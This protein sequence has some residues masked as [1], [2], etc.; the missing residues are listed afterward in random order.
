MLSFYI[1]SIP[2]YDS[3]DG[4]REYMTGLQLKTGAERPVFGSTI[5]MVR[6]DNAFDGT[7]VVPREQIDA[8]ILRILDSGQWLPKS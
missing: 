4:K 8:A 5:H 1:L 2:G 3:V 6:D 7:D